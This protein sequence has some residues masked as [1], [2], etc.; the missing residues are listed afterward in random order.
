MLRLPIGDLQR[1]R[2]LIPSTLVFGG[3]QRI[4]TFGWGLPRKMVTSQDI[5]WPLRRQ[6]QHAIRAHP[7]QPDIHPAQLTRS[8]GLGIACGARNVKGDPA[9][10]LPTQRSP[11]PAPAAEYD[12]GG[13]QTTYPAPRV[14][15]HAGP[16]N[17]TINLRRNRFPKT[18]LMN[19]CMP[20]APSIVYG[21]PPW[22]F[23]DVSMMIGW[24]W[25]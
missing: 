16:A 18:V 6:A 12:T 1:R 19:F 10:R 7:E 20:S 15:R 22:A 3:C 14:R 4:T 17:Y 5:V 25:Q 23:L 21:Y 8:R 11:P 2:G 13:P 9:A 24:A